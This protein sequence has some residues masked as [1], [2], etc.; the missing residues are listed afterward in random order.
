MCST[1]RV[2]RSRNIS[3]VQKKETNKRTHY[4]TI[5]IIIIIIKMEKGDRVCVRACEKR[6]R[7]ITTIRTYYIVYNIYI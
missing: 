7:K 4:I 2:Q 5:I 1:T 3:P 6:A